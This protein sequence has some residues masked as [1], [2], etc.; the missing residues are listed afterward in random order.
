MLP[1]EL[2]ERLARIEVLLDTYNKSLELHMRRTDLLEQRQQSV[3]ATLQ[4]I[5][6]R[7]SIIFAMGAGLL[8][9]ASLVVQLWRIF[10]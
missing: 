1:S 7:N 6:T 2:R 8:P 5:E 10:Q 3:I 4:K 9:L